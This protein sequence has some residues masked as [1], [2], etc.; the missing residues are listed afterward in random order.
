MVG[1]WTI[2]WYRTYCFE[3]TVHQIL[4]ELLFFKDYSDDFMSGELLLQFAS[5]HVETWWAVRL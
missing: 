5:D 4:I 2:R 3:V 1:I